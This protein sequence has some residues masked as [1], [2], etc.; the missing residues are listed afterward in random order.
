MKGYEAVLFDLDD[1]L[2]N[3]EK[4]VDGMFFII[5]EKCYANV[6]LST[7]KY[8]LQKFREYNKKCYGINDKTTVLDSLFDEY[9]PM[10][11]LS[12]NTIQNF[13]NDHFPNCFTIDQYIMKIENIIKRNCKVAIIT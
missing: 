7:K 6:K 12:H 13:W 3:R 11:R 1:T 5:L 4:A 9:P 8:M 2:L 10:C